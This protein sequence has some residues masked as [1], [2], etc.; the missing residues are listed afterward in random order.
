MV[1]LRPEGI[2]STCCTLARQRRFGPRLHDDGI[3]RRGCALRSNRNRPGHGYSDR[4]ND[5]NLTPDLQAQWLHK[6]LSQLG[7][8]RPVIVG[9]SW[10]GALALA[11]ALRYPNEAAGLVLVAPVA[12]PDPAFD[13]PL[14]RLAQVP[15]VGDVILGSFVT[16]FAQA[17]AAPSLKAAFAPAPVP[18]GYAQV[19][20]HLWL[21][22]SQVKAMAQDVAVL[23]P[24][25]QELSARY[26][27][28]RIPTAIVPGDADTMDPPARHALPLH[29]AIPNARL[30]VI[31][32]AGHMLLHSHH[33]AVLEGIEWAALR[34]A[35]DTQAAHD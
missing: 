6:M 31:P 21:R 14:F 16:P 25:L 22:P 30:V 26:G 23:N 9:Y 32:G 10:S 4:P 5:T 3:R 33:S 13:A 12:Y 18:V 24:A 19:A 20:T 15:L 17:I 28:I 2:W 7:V 35:T 11:Y 34:A 8:Q 27:H 1:A 29:Q